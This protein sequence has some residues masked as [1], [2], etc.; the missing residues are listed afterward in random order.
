MRLTVNLSKVELKK[1]KGD[2]AGKTGLSWL[3]YST[4][5][6]GLEKIISDEHGDKKKSNREIGANRKIV[7]GVM[8]MASGGSRVEDIEVSRAD[9]GLENSLGWKHNRIRYV[10]EFC[11]RQTVKCRKSAGQ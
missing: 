6:F 8:M 10:I 11:W 1:S 4:R 2:M 9:K 7:A 3:V 5:H